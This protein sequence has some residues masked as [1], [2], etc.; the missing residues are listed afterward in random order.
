MSFQKISNTQSRFDTCGCVVDVRNVHTYEINP[1][2]NEAELISGTNEAT[3]FYRQCE[4]HRTPQEAYLDNLK[5]N[6]MATLKESYIEAELGELK[7][8]LREVRVKDGV[9]DVL[10]DWDA[11]N[12]Y[13]GAAKGV[14]IKLSLDKEPEYIMFG[15]TAEELAVL[16]KADFGDAIVKKEDGTA[17]SVTKEEIIKE[18]I[19]VPIEEEVV[20]G[21]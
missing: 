10:R 9:E 15:H 6:D 7:Y 11:T 16:E 12:E 3:A 13:K 4:F 8:V 5:K 21:G 17:I 1:D 2:T 18:E 20:K 14:A 19:L